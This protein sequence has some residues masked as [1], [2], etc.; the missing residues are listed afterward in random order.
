MD[1]IKIIA[2]YTE[3]EEQAIT[4]DMQ[5]K[6]IP[7]WDSLTHVQIISELEDIFHISIPIEKIGSI[8]TV[9]ELMETV[10]RFS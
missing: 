10:E 2:E 7:N 5:F 4:R 8:N 6:A 3:N 9:G 1:V